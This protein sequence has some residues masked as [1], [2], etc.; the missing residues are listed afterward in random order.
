MEFMQ[1]SSLVAHFAFSGDC[2]TEEFVEI[3][4]KHSIFLCINEQDLRGGN[5]AVMWG[6]HKLRRIRLAS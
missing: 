2:C 6:I 4:C 1:V 5:I 3:D